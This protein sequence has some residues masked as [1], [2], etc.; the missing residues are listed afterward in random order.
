MNEAQ[1]LQQMQPLLYKQ[2]QK[3][4]EHGRLAHAYLFEGDTG[5]GKQEFGLWMAKH[6]FCTN[7]VNQ[8]PCNECHNC[9]RINENEHPDV[10]RIAPDGQTIKVN[11]IRELKAEFSKSGVETAKKVFLIQEADKM[12]TG[13]A[14][15]LKIFRRARRTN[16]SYF[17]NHFAFSN[18]TNDSITMPNL[19]FSTISQK[20]I[21]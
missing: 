15:S 12:S 11:Q 21:N 4:F 14:N 13:A 8:Q 7:L 20:N 18:F 19:T 2:L 16:F 3:S 9:V 17:R 5:T 6:V 1:Q 10:L